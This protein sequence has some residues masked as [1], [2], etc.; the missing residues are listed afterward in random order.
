LASR[1]GPTS[2]IPDGPRF[3]TVAVDGQDF[4][5][6]L[7]PGTPGQA[8]PVQGRIPAA[9]TIETE[10]CQ[11]AFEQLKSRGLEFE[12]EVLEFPWS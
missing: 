12:T 6:V 10:D 9:Y 3:L 5:L 7:A 8:E 11:K 2:P 1:S 4:E